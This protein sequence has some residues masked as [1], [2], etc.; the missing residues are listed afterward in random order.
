MRARGFITIFALTAILFPAAVHSQHNEI[1]NTRCLD[2]HV[3]L[4]FNPEKLSFH[5]DIEGVCRRCHENDHAKSRLS[6]P[7]GVRPTMEIPADMPLD[8]RGQLSCITCHTFHA[9][10]RPAVD[11]NPSLLRRPDGKTFCYYCHKTLR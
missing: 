7:V 11:D 3:T 4:P 8:R 2:C 9:D 1:G 6:H 10:W 5:D